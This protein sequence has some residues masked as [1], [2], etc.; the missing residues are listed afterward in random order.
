MCLPDTLGTPRSPRLP[1][2]RNSAP[3]RTEST[4]NAWSRRR[5]IRDRT[6]RRRRAPPSAGIRPRNS[7]LRCFRSRRRR[8]SCQGRPRRSR[9]TP[10]RLRSSTCWEDTA[11]RSS[12][13]LDTCPPRTPRMQ[14]PGSRRGRGCIH[15]DTRC[16]CLRASWCSQGM[17][18]MLVRHSRRNMCRR[19]RSCTAARPL[20]SILVC[21]HSNL[22]SACIPRWSSLCMLSMRHRLLCLCIRCHCKLCSCLRRGPNTLC[23]KC[24]PPF[25]R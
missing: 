24:S 7:T 4:R 11:R 2:T 10:P 18:C 13:F 8:S 16:C 21:T 9:Q 23:C 22:R 25:G 12:N 19:G 15:I 14:I 5:S 17:E 20:R 3:Q 1:R 6:R